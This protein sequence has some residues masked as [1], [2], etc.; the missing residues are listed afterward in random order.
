MNTALQKDAEHTLIVALQQI[1]NL[2]VST[3]LMQAHSS[4]APDEALMRRIDQRI[5][6][7]L[8]ARKKD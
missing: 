6:E 5:A 4:V 8:A 1:G 7:A 3:D 2:R